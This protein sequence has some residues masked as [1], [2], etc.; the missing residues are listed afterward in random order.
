MTTPLGTT[1]VATPL[2]IG[3]QC[4]IKNR[5]FK[6]AMSEQLADKNANPSPQLIHLYRE[7]AQ[8]GTGVLV[9]G[10]VMIDRNA[11]GEPRN[12]VLDEA[13]ELALFRDWANAGSG[14]GTQLWMQL[15][16]PGKQI[17]SVLCKE[18]VSA[19][20]I[21]LGGDLAGMFSRPRALLDDEILEIIRRFGW[22][23][24]QA[25][26]C[27]FSGVQIHAAHGYLCSQF[28]SPLQNHR[29]DHWGGS[30]ANRSRFVLEVYRAIRA[31]VGADFPVAIK[32]NSADFQRGGFSEDESTLLVQQLQAE[33]INLV[34]ISGGNYEQPSMVGVDQ[35]P[36]T[37][38]R[39][40]YFIEFAEQLAQRTSVPLVVTGGFRSLSTME[41]ALAEGS[42]AMIGLARPLSVMPDYSAKLLAGRELPLAMRKVTTGLAK[43]DSAVM[44]DITWYEHQ[45]ERIGR[46]K[47][48]NPNM[49]A[50][51]SVVKTFYSL[52]RVALAKRRA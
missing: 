30:F 1:N 28:L 42:C 44:L 23:A 51:R 20:A 32:L 4:Q 21:P 25:K 7:W 26:A 12:V 35:K 6:S 14:D 17:P 34:E 24:A 10:N 36:S 27:G 38:A 29:Q 33:G 31:A 41:R 13:S 45:L 49:S 16:H 50:W 47:G 8:G 5:L 52:G 2:T 46:G 37:I 15:N 3:A 40:A 48:A 39:E 11:L 43:L 22:A 19:S 18:P 9:T